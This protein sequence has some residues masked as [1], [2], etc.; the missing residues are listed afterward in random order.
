[1]KLIQKISHVLFLSISVAV[2]LPLIAAAPQPAGP[3]DQ[4]FKLT[5]E[6]IKM[7]NLSDT[8]AAE[9]RQFFDA[10]NTLTPAQKKELEDL[11][12][13]TE[14]KMRDKNLD[15]ANFDD[16]VKFMEN[17]GL[18]QPGKKAQ[19]APQAAP[20]FEEPTFPLEKPKH[21][22]IT[23]AKDTIAM[24]ESLTKHIASLRQKAPTRAQIQKRLESIRPEVSEL[25]Y[26]LNVLKAPDL[27]TLL[28]SKDFMRLHSNLEALHRALTTYEPSIIA[29]KAATI[30]EATPYEILGTPEDAS[31]EDIKAAYQTIE[32]TK[33]PRIIEAQLKEEPLDEKVR[34]QRL[35]EAQ[36]SFQHITQAYESL[37]DPDQRA[38][39]DAELAQ[40]RAIENR[41]E[42]ASRNAFDKIFNAFSTAFYHDTLLQ[43][44][45]Q[46]LEKY[47]P[48]ELEIAKK[49]LE[50][51]KKAYERSKQAVR[52]SQLPPRFG[53]FET[54]YEPFWQ[55]MMQE[56][57][58]RPYY[59]GRANGYPGQQPAAQPAAPAPAAP[60]AD[61]GKKSD[62]GKKEDKDK[63]KEEK[64]KAKKEEQKLVTRGL[65]AGDTFGQIEAILKNAAKI[66]ASVEG[67]PEEQ[68]LRS[69]PEEGANQ[70]PAGPG[71]EAILAGVTTELG[72]QPAVPMR[73]GV[74]VQPIDPKLAPENL[75]QYTE[76]LQ[77]E[78]LAKLLKD[79][80]NK[81]LP[82]EGKKITD[83][84]VGKRWRKLS[85]DY[86]ADLVEGRWYQKIYNPLVA[87]TPL[88]NAKAYNLA[89]AD[90]DPLKE[91]NK[92]GVP[93]E[94]KANLGQVRHT[95][96]AI[97]TYFA[98][99]DEAAKEEVPTNKPDPHV[100]HPVGPDAE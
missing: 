11:G 69:K 71:L 40:K 46:L 31:I 54:G 44:V 66:D 98:A 18:S 95:I 67:A 7:L 30:D 80:L 20:R 93:E 70:P 91:L 89:S 2:T 10:L 62:G 15:P 22:P 79:L 85:K 97:H 43:T 48:H 63:E 29:R 75:M 51:E 60:Q 68:P 73:G 64:K 86:K 36:R 16:L 4:A 90:P 61:K 65:E 42:R 25:Y 82:K 19:P 17:E 99:L 96:N 84:A 47:K 53:G 49:Q 83:E 59:P 45:Q 35:K 33:H 81:V 94:G 12:K 14:K 56:S 87:A 100:P 55:K 88:R 6:E 72:G 74:Q 9:L 58:Q 23:S 3:N 50:L 57:F 1:M 8:E 21:A 37:I 27:V 38:I 39:I 34:K 24:L 13:E 32:E 76:V 77:L 52:V 92:P 28:T 26:Y 41:N 5:D 78:Q